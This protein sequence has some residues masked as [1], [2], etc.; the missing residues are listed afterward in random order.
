ML[1]W[2]RASRL[3]RLPGA[4]VMPG[5][6]SRRVRASCTETGTQPGGQVMP[7]SLRP[8]AGEPGR[9]GDLQDLEAAQRSRRPVEIILPAGQG[10]SGGGLRLRGAGLGGADVAGDGLQHVLAGDP[11]LQVLPVGGDHREAVAA[12]EFQLAQRLGQGFPGEEHLR[13]ALLGDRAGQRRLA[14]P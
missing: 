11:A 6:G 4:R 1:C 7:P 14:G 13:I 9:D 5:S 10:G 3:T 8:A 12:V 2:V